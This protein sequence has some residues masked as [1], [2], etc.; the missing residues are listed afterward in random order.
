[1]IR[2]TALF[3]LLITFLIGF[4]TAVFAQKSERISANIEAVNQ[5]F[6]QDAEL[7]NDNEVI[8]LS[9][10]IISE[11]E[12][13]SN[14]ILAKVF[15]LLSDSASNSGDLAR[16]MQ[17]AQ[18]GVELIGVDRSL[19]L[20]LKLKVTSG[21]YYKGKF[22]QAKKH[23][24]AAV[25]L[26]EQ[27]NHIEFHILALCYRAMAN[28][29]INEHNLALEDLDQ[30]QRLL[31][32]H[33][34]FKERIELLSVSANARYYIGD[35]DTAIELYHKILKLRFSMERT[36]NIDQTY[37]NLARSYL[38]SGLL[39]DAYNAFLE[40]HQHASD[41]K[42]PIR[43]A[44][45]AS[46]LGQVFFQQADYKNALQYFVYAN[47]GFKGYNLPHPYLTSLLNLAKVLEKLEQQKESFYYLKKAE[48]LMV[49][50]E[51][52]EDQIEL[53]LLLANMYKVLNQP[54]KAIEHYLLY[55][56][57]EQQFSHKHHLSSHMLHSS[58]EANN[59]SRDILINV[60]T[61]ATLSNEYQVKFQQQ[62]KL[63]VI[64][65]SII[66]ILL[67]VILWFGFKFR[68][69]RLNT[70]YDEVERP[71]DYILGPTETKKMYQYHFKMARK[72]EV[73]VAVGYFTIENWDELSF[74]FSQ[75]VLN[76]VSS[77]IATI[78]NETNDEFIQVGLIN[79]GEYLFLAPYHSPENLLQNL[80]KIA[81]SIEMHFF[82]NLG[83]FSLKVSYDCQ[84][85]NIQDIDPYIFLSRLSD[86]TKADHSGYK[87]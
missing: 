30:V 40:A 11:R 33:T 58:N 50:T 35:N 74:Q 7:L 72:F 68:A 19:N 81:K 44:H 80:D 23:A 59:K 60:A 64:L 73:P 37:V 82:A 41:K 34:H 51:L 79:Q 9:Q 75:R 76:E 14:N 31:A 13:Y 15:S 36:S 46:G 1:M 42:A 69:H 27:L 77:A 49:T 18:D 83:E 67:L 55:A 63:I 22:Q 25:L 39:D 61:E 2:R 5:L 53:H 62:G 66:A 45:A 71:V 32:T 56:N 85:P 38:T 48:T 28:A 6:E 57:L 21:F 87:L 43:I 26:A 78:I 4:S 3:C 65:S 8:A 86:S 24:Q 16:A 70:A 12:L 17:F 54:E 52:T 29:L 10:K 84:T 47:E 20:K